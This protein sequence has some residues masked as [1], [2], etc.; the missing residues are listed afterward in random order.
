[1]GILLLVLMTACL[2]ELWP[3]VALSGRGTKQELALSGTIPE[4]GL[5]GGTPFEE[6]EG[7]EAFRGLSGGSKLVL[8]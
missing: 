7:T 2:T 5:T 6:I 1:M 8:E 4:G 3:E